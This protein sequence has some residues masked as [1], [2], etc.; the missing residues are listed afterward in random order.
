MTT[1]GGGWT[2]VASIHENNLYGKCTNGDRWTSQQGNNINCPGG[3][4]NWANY[5]T[6]GLPEGATSDDYKNPGYYDIFAGDLQIWHVPNKTPM[7][8]WMTMALQ[9]FRTDNGFLFAEGGNLYRLYNKYPLVYNIGACPVNNGPAIPIVYDFGDVRKT[10]N[11]YGPNARG[12]FTPGFIQFS[13]FNYERAAI[14]LCPGMKANGCNTEHYCIGGGGF[15][16]DGNPAQC[17]DFTN[18]DANGYGTNQGWSA[19]REITEAA[20]LLFYR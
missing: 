8:K 17:G 12:E 18:Y 20:V 15:F 14:A 2:L 10:S 3:D 4:G 7:A 1:D 11:Y 9:R 16:P 13:V 5:N 6:F 19:S